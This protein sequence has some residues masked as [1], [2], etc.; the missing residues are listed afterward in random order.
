M[1]A[2]KRKGLCAVLLDRVD[3]IAELRKELAKGIRVKLPA[4]AN[5][6]LVVPAGFDESVRIGDRDVAISVR[7]GA[8]SIT[9]EMLWYGAIVDVDSAPARPTTAS[10]VAG[11][12]SA[13]T[14]R[15]G[16]EAGMAAAGS[17]QLKRSLT[18]RSE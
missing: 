11:P 17:S 2:E 1:L 10:P 4:A 13:Q 3:V 8:I 5:Q 16:R 12:V 14:L 15:P 9:S 7:P 18:I 6:W